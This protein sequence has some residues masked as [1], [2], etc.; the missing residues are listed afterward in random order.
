M[1]G[2]TRAVIDHGGEPYEA[3]PGTTVHEHYGGEIGVSTTDPGDASA[4]GVGRFDIR[5]DDVQVR[6][7]SRIR[8]RSDARSYHVEIDLDLHEGDELRWQR[9]WK[10]SIPRHLQ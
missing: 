5:W 10:R 2:R 6:S 4:E 7:E 9:R 3:A 1:R 8:M